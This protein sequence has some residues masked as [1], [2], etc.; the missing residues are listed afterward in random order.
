MDESSK[1]DD[2]CKLINKK[3][4]LKERIGEGGMGE[5]YHAVDVFSKGERAIKFLKF[6]D[7][8]VEESVLRLYQEAVNL[9][10][11]EHP[12]IIRLYEVAQV[13]DSENHILVMGYFAGE[14]LQAVLRREGK[15]PVAQALA[16]VKQIAQGL[17]HAHGNKIFHRDIKPEN[18]LLNSEGKVKIA[19]FGIAKNA[20]SEAVGVTSGQ[21]SSLRYMS[22]E[23]HAAQEVDFSTDLY[24]L[25]LV[26]YEML[27]GKAFVDQ[28]LEEGSLFPSFVPGSVQAIVRQLLQTK[29]ANRTPSATQLIQELEAEAKRVNNGPPVAEGTF[30]RVLAFLRKARSFKKVFKVLGW[31]V[32]AVVIFLGILIMIGMWVT[33]PDNDRGAEETEEITIN[34]K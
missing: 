10:R 20:D 25:G 4:A 8:N 11:L 32:S 29:P 31:A 14:S 2:T 5:V 12:N 34:Q 28:E 13:E 1:I 22:P 16:I 27:T 3:Y 33:P 15:L 24:S 19:D 30:D 9:D 6:Y 26:M 7:D 23:Q 17:E 21:Y 18:I